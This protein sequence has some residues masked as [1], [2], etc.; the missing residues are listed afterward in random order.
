MSAELPFWAVFLFALGQ[1][2]PLAIPALLVAAGFLAGRWWHKFR[3][4]QAAARRALRAHSAQPL[5]VEVA[6]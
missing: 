3:V 5:N 1:F 4:H 2:G 6:E